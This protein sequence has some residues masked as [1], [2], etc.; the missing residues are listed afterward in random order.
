MT[1]KERIRLTEAFGI[2]APD[3]KSEFTEEFRRFDAKQH[4]APLLPIVMRTAAAAAVVAIVIGVAAHLPKNRLGFNGKN[5][6]STPVTTVTTNINGEGG[7]TAVSAA[8][9][10]KT[11]VTSN[12]GT[13]TT[14][15]VRTNDKNDAKGTDGSKST[16]AAPAS[17]AE[18]SITTVRTTASEPKPEEATAAATTDRIPETS[19]TGIPVDM[20]RTYKDLRVAPEVV[21]PV[22]S[23]ILDADDLIYNDKGSEEKEDF[24]GR[25]GNDGAKGEDGTV[26]EMFKNSCAV[27]LAKVDKKVYTSIGGS[28][29]TAADLTVEKVFK[30]DLDANDRLTVFVSGG[31]IPAE[32]FLRIHP[33]S[34]YIDDP[35]NTSVYDHAGSRFEL[36]DGDSCIFFLD[37]SGNELPDGSFIPHGKE[38]A[39]IFELTGAY[40][41]SVAGG[42]YFRRDEAEQ[43]LR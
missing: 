20:G 1:E 28:P 32:E 30:G 34:R 18:G 42:L 10:E 26:S 9:T 5:T 22:R 7:T 3:R 31:C 33:E 13:V 11:S 21:Y 25:P 12:T 16:S 2:P 4:K 17:S 6:E 41:C 19:R 43:I 24:T 36:T 40:Y 37:R 38:S 14:S 35:Y 29:M 23:N 27:V 8:V 39:G 15:A